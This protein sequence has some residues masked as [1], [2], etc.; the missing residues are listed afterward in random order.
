MKMPLNGITPYPYNHENWL[1]NV[2]YWKKHK[3]P[4]DRDVTE[5]MIE[6]LMEGKKNAIQNTELPTDN[7]GMPRSNKSIGRKT[8]RN[9]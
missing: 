2:E 5:V 9:K 6:E 8:E 4:D 3:R 1:K 7:R